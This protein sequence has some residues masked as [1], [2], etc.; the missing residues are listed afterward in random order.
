MTKYFEQMREQKGFN[1]FSNHLIKQIEESS[2]DLYI[3]SDL[4]LKC[5]FQAFSMTKQFK[6]HFI[7]VN[8][9]T[10]S[11]M[12][13]GWFLKECDSH[14]TEIHLDDCKEWDVIFNN[15]DTIDQLKHEVVK[16]LEAD[17]F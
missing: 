8:A 16:W 11:K 7:R 12:K 14:F 2:H 13:R 10:E 3:I 6:S 1:F 15:D 9:K 4:R 5:D 17:V